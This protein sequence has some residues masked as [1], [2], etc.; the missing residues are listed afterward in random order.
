MMPWH[1]AP[2]IDL[3]NIISLAPVLIPW[4]VPWRNVTEKFLL[5]DLLRADWY[6]EQVYRPRARHT[7]TPS[8]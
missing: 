3:G 4:L 6:C 1:E 8:G 2:G 5:L 7:Q